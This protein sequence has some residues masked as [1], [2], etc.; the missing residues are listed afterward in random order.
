[1]RLVMMTLLM[2]VSIIGARAEEESVFRGQLFGSGYVCPMSIAPQD[3]SKETARE[4][5]KVTWGGRGHAGGIAQVAESESG[6]SMRSSQEYVKIVCTFGRRVP[7]ERAA[8]Q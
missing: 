5:I 4:I 8:T 6:Q 1:M 3:C 7:H 2:V